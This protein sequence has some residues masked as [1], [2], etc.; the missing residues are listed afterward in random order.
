MLNGTIVRN[1]RGRLLWIMTAALVMILVF[2][3]AQAEDWQSE[4]RSMLTLINSF[5][6]GDNAWYW[7]RDN[8]TK[9]VETGL[10]SLIY[11]Y[12]LEEVAK[13]RAEEISRKF[14]HT[15]PDGSKWSTA[16]P[17]GNYYKGENIA[18]GFESAADAF[19]GFLEEAEDYAGQGHR[20]N[21]LHRHYTRVGLAAVE[22]DGTVYW[23]QE[24]ASGSVSGAGAG[25]RNGRWSL[26]NG[27]Y[28]Y[29][30]T[31]GS[32]A[33]RWL[34]NGGSWYYLD[35][36]GALQTGWVRDNGAWY[37]MDQTGVMQTGWVQA[38]GNWYL[39]DKSGVMQTGWKKDNGKWYF[40]DGNGILKTG[41]IQD[42]GNWFFANSKG[43]MQTGWVRD[44]EKW[45]HFGRT[46]TMDTG[47][48]KEAGKWYY[49]K[50]NGEMITGR[51]TV[52]GQTEV[53]DD[54]G[55]W[56]Y[57]EIG[58]YDTPLGTESWIVLLRSIRFYLNHILALI[59]PTGGMSP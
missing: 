28:H 31:D 32:S 38:D 48:V 16:F 56:Q 27:K 13:I 14:S 6:T 49:C 1:W 22:V 9:T 7:N 58:E 10:S 25:S 42:G 57:S 18:C 17:A 54:Y 59:L 21:M 8:Q 35:T 26:E 4:A 53:F 55:V 45:Y 44:G 47:W 52:D 37:Y 34:Q 19:G 46:G 2:S 29:R 51:C 24:F 3:F 11:D 20:R 39:L 23:V 15:R 36:D 12:Q 43:E 30:Y 40:F 50:E 33:T 5:R 41:W